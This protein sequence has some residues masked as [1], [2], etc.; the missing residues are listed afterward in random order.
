MWLLFGLGVIG[1]GV[2]ELFV[3]VPA[4]PVA[5]A[6]SAAL[7]P[8]TVRSMKLVLNTGGFPSVDPT[9]TPITVDRGLATLQALLQG[10]RGAPGGVVEIVVESMVGPTQGQQAAILA[11]A[12]QLSS[13]STIA[14]PLITALAHY[15]PNG[16]ALGLAKDYPQLPWMTDEGSS[17]DIGVNDYKLLTDSNGNLHATK[18]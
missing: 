16:K 5:P 13:Q 6:G 8:P 9:I 7:P 14:K 18:V 10:A 1:F 15:V 4:V 2:Y 12:N 11:K 3:K 17:I